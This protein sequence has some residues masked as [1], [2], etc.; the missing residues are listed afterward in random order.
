MKKLLAI[1]TA[2]CFTT[3]FYMPINSDS[4][5]SGI[6]A[7]A[8]TASSDFEFDAETGTVKKYLGSDS[9]VVIPSEINGI[10]V[11]SI[12]DDAFEFWSQ[13]QILCK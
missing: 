8:E 7:S 2:L 12:G 1:I 3:G 9:E 10:T 11:T 6:S 5:L 4:V 13:S